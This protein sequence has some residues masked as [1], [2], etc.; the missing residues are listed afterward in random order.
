MNLMTAVLLAPP[1]LA[2]EATQGEVMV[3]SYYEA[4]GR[5]MLA[6]HMLISGT[7]A[8]AS[9]ALDDAA[10]LARHITGPKRE[11]LEALIG[12][13]RDDVAAATPRS[14]DDWADLSDRIA[15]GGWAA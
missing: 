7:S 5:L 2:P 6:E 12:D 15:D 10:R 4:L 11:H 9:R 8:G 1:A 14:N 13:G 3:S